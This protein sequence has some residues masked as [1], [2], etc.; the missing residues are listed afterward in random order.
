[1]IGAGVRGSAAGRV[2][3]AGVLAL[4]LPAVPLSVAVAGGP[5]AP[6][7]LAAGAAAVALLAAWLGPAAWPGTGRAPAVERTLVTATIAWAAALDAAIAG[8]ALR[9][10]EVSRSPAVIAVTALAYAVGSVWSLRV[11][12][13]VWWR[14]P[15]ACSLVAVVWIAGQAAV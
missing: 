7:V 14:W 1:V 2:A 8:M 13:D 15:V 9:G 4:A 11:A 6:L 12:A 3:A 10:G 5:A